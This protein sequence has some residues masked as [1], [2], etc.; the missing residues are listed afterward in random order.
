MNKNSFKDD[1]DKAERMLLI[2]SWAGTISA[3][4]IIG[5]S[6]LTFL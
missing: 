2:F 6:L 3:L 1:I 4:A 5:Y